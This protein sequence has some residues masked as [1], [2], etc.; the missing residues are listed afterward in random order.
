MQNKHIAVIITCHNRC[1]RTIACLKSLYNCRLPEMN[2]IDVF[3]VDDGSSDGTKELVNKK[4]PQ[5]KVIIG[6]GNLFWNQGMRLA[7]ETAAQTYDYDFY[8]WLNDD[9]NLFD[10]ALTEF[11]KMNQEIINK[12]GSRPAIICGACKTS[13][14]SNNF[15]YGGRIE[16]G[17]VF[18]NGH[19]Q[20]CKYI[21]GNAVLVPK[22]IF[23]VL[24][25]LSPDYT[26][27]M[28]DYDYGLRAF[29]KNYKCY[30]T[31]NYVATCPSN[32]GTAAW[33]N[34]KI[35]FK[36]RWKLFHS[37]KGLN[38]NEYIIFRRKFW[39]WKWIIYA[40]KAYM[41]TI[42]PGIYY[43]IVKKSLSF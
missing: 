40:S 11:L 3:L 41:K 42:F 2:Q 4:F 8:L 26:H 43:K 39:G 10:N 38:I 35:P 27:C 33:C 37:P 12:D 21:N 20:Q 23:H 36:D 1:E 18:P 29:Q 25:N 15:S 14:E 30:T 28:G 6:S 22:E 7:W 31:K 19:F 32:E 16:S 5:V 34:P 24:G 13:D 17:P 9:T